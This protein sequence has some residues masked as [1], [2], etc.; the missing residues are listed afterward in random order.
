MSILE[1]ITLPYFQAEIKRKIDRLW[2]IRG[3]IDELESEERQLEAEILALERGG[4][5][6]EPNIIS[7]VARFMDRERSLT[8][9]EIEAL[10]EILCGNLSR[11]ALHRARGIFINHIDVTIQI[12]G[13]MVA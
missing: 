1:S 10:E 6:Q 13:R 12:D 5:D 7:F 9:A 8:G 2:D 3:E 4:G 11:E